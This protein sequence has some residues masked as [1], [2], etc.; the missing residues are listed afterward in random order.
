[1]L[2]LLDGMVHV[3]EVFISAVGSVLGG[4]ENFG[5]WGLMMKT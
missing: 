5:T 1:M 2:A 3:F 4:Y